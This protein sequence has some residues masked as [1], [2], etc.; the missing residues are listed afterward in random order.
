L[1]SLALLNSEFAR[2]RAGG[3]AQRLAREVGDDAG[4]RLTL[5]YRLACGRPPDDHERAACEAFLADQRA[6]YAKEKD[7]EPRAW[8]DLGQMILASN[9]FLYVE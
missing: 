8:A 7:A 3:F 6:I 9:A 4:K 1:Q 5:A 2:A